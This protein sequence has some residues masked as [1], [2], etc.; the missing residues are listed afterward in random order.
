MYW[1][2]LYHFDVEGHY[3]IEESSRR[4]EAVLDGHILCR[5]GAFFAGVTYD[6]TIEEMQE[7]MQ[8]ILRRRSARDAEIDKSFNEAS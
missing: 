1:S 3:I 5:L 2:H 6:Q 8:R 4:I 7:E